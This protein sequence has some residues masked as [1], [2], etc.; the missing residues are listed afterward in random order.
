MGWASL[1]S[2]V[3]PPTNALLQPHGTG[4]RRVVCCPSHG[5]CPSVVKSDWRLRPGDR[6]WHLAGALLS[7]KAPQVPEGTCHAAAAWQD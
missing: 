5:G 2:L 1:G 6:P 7:S 3:G 4:R